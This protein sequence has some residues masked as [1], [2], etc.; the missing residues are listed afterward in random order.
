MERPPVD[1]SESEILAFAKAWVQLAADQGFE[2]ALAELA[3]S[4]LTSSG[5]LSVIRS[6][7]LSQWSVRSQ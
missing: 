3:S 6:A 4:L 1:A 2:A 7:R 5:Q